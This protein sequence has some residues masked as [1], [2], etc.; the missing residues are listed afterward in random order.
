LRC[1]YG[2]SRGAFSTFVTQHNF[3][4]INIAA[5]PVANN[6]V[7]RFAHGLRCTLIEYWDEEEHAEHW[8]PRLTRMMIHGA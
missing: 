8:S 3:S 6:G 4:R 1:F 5:L 2:A 7:L